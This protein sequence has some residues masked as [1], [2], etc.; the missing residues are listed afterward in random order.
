MEVLLWLDDN[1]NPF[2]N[3]ENKVPLNDKGNPYVIHWVRN[4]EEFK[5]WVDA[6][7][8]PY[9][10][11]FDHDLADEHYTPEYFWNDYESSKKFQDWKKETYT[12]HTGEECAKFLIGYCESNNKVMPKI[13]IHSANP[14][15]ANYIRKQ[16]N[17]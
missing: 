8:I 2:L 4:Y 5:E 9:A 13:F 10:V 14:V 3:K 6:N 1:R 15:G 16:L 11:S 7:E 17:K 12:E